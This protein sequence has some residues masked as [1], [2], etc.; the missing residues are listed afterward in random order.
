MVK[1]FAHVALLA[2][3]IVWVVPFI[4]L[5]TTSI[6]PQK[7]A[8]ETGF[9]RAYTTMERGHAVRTLGGP[10]GGTLLIEGNLF[11]DIETAHQIRFERAN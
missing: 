8:N 4:G 6:R 2:V 7:N 3:V 5:L 11:D 1:L 10:D 9:W